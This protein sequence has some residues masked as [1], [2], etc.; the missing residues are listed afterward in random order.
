MK[1]EVT[2]KNKCSYRAVD[3]YFDITDG[4]LK[5]HN[6]FVS[7]DWNKPKHS[8][9]CIVYIVVDNILRISCKGDVEEFDFAEGANKATDIK[10]WLTLIS[11]K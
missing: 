6:L 3:N 1:F 11:S 10:N 5:I 4:I 7:T 9:P 2:T 8:Q